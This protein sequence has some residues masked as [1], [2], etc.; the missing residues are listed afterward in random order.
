LIVTSAVNALLLKSPRPLDAAVACAGL[1]TGFL[2]PLILNFVG[3]YIDHGGFRGAPGVHY[4]SGGIPFALLVVAIAR[5]AG[6]VA[7][8]RAVA[9]G[10]ATLVAMSTAI[11]LSANTNNALGDIREPLRDLV[12]GP[13]GGVVGSG[14]MVLAA[15]LLGVGP[16]NLMR[17]LPLVAV[18]AVL[19]VVMVF[20]FW[21]DADNVWAL[22]PVWQASVALV[23]LRTVQRWRATGP[24]PGA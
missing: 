20:D 5:F 7:W 4:A 13:V 21:R 23:F 8:W 6:E 2:T 15:A 16:A 3:T 18:G 11:I 19:G 17:W 9:L 12:S 14:L 22:F 24:V 1:V 10:F